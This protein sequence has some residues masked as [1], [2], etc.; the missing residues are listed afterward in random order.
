MGPTADSSQN[1]KLSYAVHGDGQLQSAEL[2]L[3]DGLIAIAQFS[4]GREREA[5]A[6]VAAAWID[7]VRPGKSRS[8]AGS[9][10]A[11]GPAAW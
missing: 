4:A 1:S 11:A 7:T 5:S 8:S 10:R 2:T 6:Q 9:A 3:G